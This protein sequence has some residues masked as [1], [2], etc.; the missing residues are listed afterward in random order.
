MGILLGRTA[1]AKKS[2]LPKK[3]PTKKPVHG[4]TTRKMTSPAISSLASKILRGEK[5]AT[6]ADAKKLAASVLSQDEI[7]GQPQVKKK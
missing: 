7:H 3:A 4:I 2:A 6:Q 5:T 1:M